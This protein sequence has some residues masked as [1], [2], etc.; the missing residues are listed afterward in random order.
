M[1]TEPSPQPTTM[2]EVVR[3]RFYYVV[4]RVSTNGCREQYNWFLSLKKAEICAE[5]LASGTWTDQGPIMS[6]F[7]VD[8]GGSFTD[9]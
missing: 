2:Y 6:R 4:D 3:V 7:I 5:G 1:V 8:D 9:D